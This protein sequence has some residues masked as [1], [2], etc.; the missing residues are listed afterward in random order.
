MGGMAAAASV[1]L[2]AGGALYFSRE[3]NL[4]THR[5]DTVAELAPLMPE[6]AEEAAG[7]FADA[8]AKPPAGAKPAE[9]AK[10][11]A[12]DKAEAQATRRAAEPPTPKPMR[13]PAPEAKEKTLALVPPS[14]ARMRAQLP[15]GPVAAT[16]M[17][18]E[19]P[20]DGRRGA[21]LGGGGGDVDLDALR[22]IA[23]GSVAKDVGGM[24]LSGRANAGP[25]PAA[26][27]PAAA[28]PRPAPMPDTSRSAAAAPPPPAFAPP[29]DEWERA[30]SEPRAQRQEGASGAARSFD[31]EKKAAAESLAKED[32]AQAEKPAA[33]GESLLAFAQAA[34]ARGEYDKAAELFGKVV[35]VK[36][37]SEAVV[38]AA[39]KGRI[40][41]LV[42]LGRLDEAER[43]RAEYLPRFPGVGV[44]IPAAPRKASV[45]S[46]A[47]ESD[48]APAARPEPASEAPASK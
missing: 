16:P 37:A 12:R 1:A 36:G 28:A 3:T 41:A 21:A 20:A 23:A 46:F 40:G 47:T 27:P 44:S 6:A 25:A 45:R 2:V 19:L 31:R 17:P 29:L 48:A 15:A 22:Q 32:D 39:M 34:L 11:E 10:L 24:K 5:D 38:R 8:P 30:D 7:P 26:P 4:A 13:T 9:E 43:A 14:E 35:E 33:P 18:Q 42:A